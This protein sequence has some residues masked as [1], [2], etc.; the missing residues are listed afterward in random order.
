MSQILNERQLRAWAAAE[1]LTLGHGGIVAVAESTG[2]GRRTIWEGMRE[3]RDGTFAEAPERVRRPGAGR[4]K[5]EETDPEF[6]EELNRL[7]DPATRGDPMSPLLW[8]SKSTRNLSEALA[9]KGHRVSPSTLC[10]ILASL[11]FSLQAPQKQKEGKQHP[12][13]NGQFEYINERAMSFHEAGLPVISVDT[14]KKELVGDFRGSGREWMPKG[15]PLR[16]NV[17]DFPSDAVGKAVPYGIYDIFNNTGWVN[18]GIDHDT[19]QF[20]ANSIL[21][22]WN[23]MGFPLYP[24]AKELLVIADSGGSNSPRTRLWKT[25]VQDLT[26]QTGLVIHISHFP[27]G[28]SKWNKIE[29]R[30]FAHITRNWRGRPL[31]SFEAVVEL[32]A[33][34]STREGL[35]LGASLDE[36]TYPTGI[37]VSDEDLEAV[38]L[39]PAEW[40]GEWNYAIEPR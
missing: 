36:G 29:H 37:K 7:I 3:L 30:M 35:S 14:K 20:A 25:A 27:P 39:V 5:K 13:R 21:V 26:D 31:T 24:N 9:E 19:A 6:V 38:S 11:G 2:M 1:A 16:V 18:V 32:I 22:W 10:K 17:H 33:S 8:T 12:D 15:K 23:E 34:T 40:H 4:P 28:T